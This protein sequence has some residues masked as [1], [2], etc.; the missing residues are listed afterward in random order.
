MSNS[1]SFFKPVIGGKATNFPDTIKWMTGDLADADTAGG[2]L[3][4]ANPE[5]SSIIVD[6]VIIDVTTAATGAATI[7]V[8][9]AANGTT[10]SDTLIDGLDVNTAT[11]IF[12]NID[13]QGTNGNSVVKLTTSQY[14]TASEATGDVSD[15]AGKYYI[16]YRTI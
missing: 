5:T 11:G 12:D 10:S 13:D 3:S 16:R 7:D 8:G 14:I 1:T 15:L 4:V 9:V 2:V 6:R